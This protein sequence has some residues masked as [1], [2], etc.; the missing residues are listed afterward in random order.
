MS[1]A[2]RVGPLT[3]ADSRSTQL[4]LFV[5]EDTCEI[6]L[7]DKRTSLRPPFLPG[8]LRTCK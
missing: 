6:L 1:F 5:E 8:I 3:P 4:G 7:S 2:T